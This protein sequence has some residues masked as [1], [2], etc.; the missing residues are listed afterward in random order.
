[1]QQP[2]CVLKFADAGKACKDGDDCA[3]DCL[4]KNDAGFAPTGATATGVCAV[5]DD[6]CGCKQTVEDGRATAAICID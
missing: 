5:N 3:G 6:P 2:A 4:A 1:M